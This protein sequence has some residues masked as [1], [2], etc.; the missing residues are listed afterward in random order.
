FAGRISRIHRRHRTMDTVRYPWPSSQIV[1]HLVEKSSGYFIYVATVIKFIDDRQFDPCQR[2]NIIMGSMEDRYSEL[3]FAPLDQLYLQILSSVPMRFHR[4]LLQILV[5]IHAQL[6]LTI[7]D[8]E[9]LLELDEGDVE[10]TLRR[11]HS[12]ISAENKH[13]SQVT[14]YHASFLDFL[15]DS[16]RSGPF[17]VGSSQCRTNLSLHLLK[18]FSCRNGDPSFNRQEKLAW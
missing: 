5:A 7:S 13:S 17:H 14:V 18:A 1:Q 16:S 8:L 15:E 12:V 10:L 4:S 6:A 9:P 2:L 3:P 11:L